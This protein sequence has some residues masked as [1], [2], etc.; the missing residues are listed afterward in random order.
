MKITLENQ[1]PLCCSRDVRHSRKTGA[2]AF[3]LRLSFLDPYRCR[4]CH[5]HFF[6]LRAGR[7]ADHERLAAF[8][9]DTP[10]AAN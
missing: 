5:R 8:G 10:A 7:A 9:R 6:R 3:L 1:C 4:R 2:L